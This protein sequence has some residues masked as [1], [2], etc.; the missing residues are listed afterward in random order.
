MAKDVTAVEI[1]AEVRQIKSMADHTY[2]ITLNVPEYCV[3]QVKVM[4][5]WLQS[6]VKVV[7]EKEPR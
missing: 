1:E 3:E 7:I 4:L 2:N 6:Q 5:D